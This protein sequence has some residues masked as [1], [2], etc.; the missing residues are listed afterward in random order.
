MLTFDTYQVEAYKTAIYSS[1]YE[2]SYPA[3]GLSAEV[4]EALNKVKKIYRDHNGEVSSELAEKIGDELGDALWYIAALCTDLGLSLNDI[5]QGNLD[6][7]AIR[8]ETNE[9]QGDNRPF[10][11]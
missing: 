4:G 8:Q 1:Q 10:G 3:L 11:R 5:A 2:I 7:L 6:K 9:L